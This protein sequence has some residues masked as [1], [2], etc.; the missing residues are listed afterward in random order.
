MVSF[1]GGQRQRGPSGRGRQRKFNFVFG[2]RVLFATAFVWRSCRAV[3]QITGLVGVN[4]FGPRAG[5]EPV[6]G[7]GSVGPVSSLHPAG[8]RG[9]TLTDFSLT[10]EEGEENDM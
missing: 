5:G 4:V 8:L 7:V 2:R 3:R 1:Y 9:R 10:G 6:V